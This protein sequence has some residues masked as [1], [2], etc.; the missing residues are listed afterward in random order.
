MMTASDQQKLINA[1]FRIIRCD[2]LQNRIKYQ[3]QGSHAHG[4][5]LLEKDFSSK[6]ALDRRRKEL[7]EDP[8]TVEG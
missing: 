8:M 4:W 7:L 2:Y 5:K 3:S 1:G 6:T